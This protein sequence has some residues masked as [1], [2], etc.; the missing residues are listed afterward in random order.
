MKRLI[1]TGVAVL[2]AQTAMLAEAQT[3]STLSPVNAPAKPGS[4][5][6]QMYDSAAITKWASCAWVKQPISSENWLKAFQGSVSPAHASKNPM[7][8]PKAVLAL[9]LDAA[10]G[11]LLTGRDR[12]SISFGV[13]R[14]KAKA[15]QESRPTAIPAT[16]PKSKVLV[17]EMWSG[18]Q[19]MVTTLSSEGKKPKS[20]PGA[21]VRCFKT[22][23]DGSLINA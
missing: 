4:A 13:E 23:E 1:L 2:A 17:C 15:L 8:Q 22:L 21:Q 10:C 12:N 19:L 14:A 5:I 20:P 6:I 7:A 11:S 9:R 3:G 18:G 16:E